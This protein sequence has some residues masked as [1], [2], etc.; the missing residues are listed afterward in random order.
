MSRVA[1]ADAEDDPRDDFIVEHHD[2]DASKSDAISDAKSG[3][4]AFRGR[5]FG[6][7]VLLADVPL[8]AFVAS[9]PAWPA[10]VNTTPAIVGGGFAFAIAS[11]AIHAVHGSGGAMSVA[12][13]ILL[14]A[15]GTASGALLGALSTICILECPAPP[16]MSPTAL[17]AAIG[18]A[19]TAGLG[20]LVDAFAFAWD[21]DDTSRA[22]S[23]APVRWT[24]APS[25]STRGGSLT[26]RAAF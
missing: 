19:T 11:P 18:F 20:A 5:W 4:R 13:H 12:L 22:S 2:D 3:A 24:I 23:R 17:G 16:A 9:T 26:L 21:D 8:I 14:P 10:N 6:W 25:F 1:R 7:Q 15:V